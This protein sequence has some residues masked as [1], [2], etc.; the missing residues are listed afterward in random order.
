MYIKSWAYV[1]TGDPISIP[2]LSTA[3][4]SAKD[5]RKKSAKYTE[6]S[7]NFDVE[8]QDGPQVSYL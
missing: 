6:P 4:L 5:T 3:H 8:M 1:W 7:S 2:Q